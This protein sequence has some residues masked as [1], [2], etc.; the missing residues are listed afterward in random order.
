MKKLAVSTAVLATMAASPAF[1]SGLSVDVYGDRAFAGDKK[2]NSTQGV[3]V[4][5]DFENGLSLSAEATTNKD[6]DL[7]AAWKF[8]LT[9]SVYLQ[10]SVGYVLNDSKT[11]RAE[12][13][14][15]DG[16]YEFLELTGTNSDVAK[17]GLEFGY[18]NSQFFYTLRGRYE[19]NTSKLALT[20][21][22]GG[23]DAKGNPVNV[24]RH[25]I[26][27][28][29]EIARFDSLIG[30]RFDYVTL[31]AK[32]IRKFELNKDIKRLNREMNTDNDRWSGEFKATVTAWDG[33]A[34]YVEYTHDKAFTQ[35]GKD[36]QIIKIG[37]KFTF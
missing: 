25:S 30:Y 22:T 2:G 35:H 14:N 32:G 13:P 4:G 18:D 31:T 10:P 6:L 3:E 26:G 34:P 23:Y 24:E 15:V 21:E 33:V 17:A 37:T 20:H 7:D 29:S 36:D 9:E 11:Y 28:R 27:A 19:A 5:Y 12:N 8:Q 16:G 1:A